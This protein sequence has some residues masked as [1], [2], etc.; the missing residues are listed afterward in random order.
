M[1]ERVVIKNF[2]GIKDADI[3]FNDKIN[4]IVGNNGV[5][6]STLIEAIA[7]AL[8]Y[9]I[10]Q[11]EITQYLF[12]ATTWK[13]FDERKTLPE[14]VIELYFNESF[15]AEYS[16]KNNSLSLL[17]PGIRLRIACDNSYLTLF[18]EQKEQYKHI[19]CEFY[20]IDRHWFSGETVKQLLIPFTPW[21]ID[22][23]SNTFNNKA[24]QL[25][26]RLISHKLSDTERVQVK[27]CLRALREHFE[28]DNK[29]NEIN[30]S[31]ND[32][33]KDV[34]PDFKLTVDL[35]T[36]TAWNTIL[37]PVLKDIPFSQIGLGDQCIVN[38]LLSLDS[39]NKIERK[40][41]LLI[42]EEPESHLSHTKMYEL[43][44]CL[45]DFKGQIFIT[46]HSSY[47]ANK[48][49]LSNL[50]VL[51]NENGKIC[52]QKIFDLDD[53]NFFARVPNYPTLR[54][55]L[56]KKAIL[57]EGPTD[58]MVLL[59]HFMKEY[60]CHPFAMNIELI[61]VGGVVFKH[62]AQLGA[63]LN[64]KIAIITDNDS[65]PL[66]ELKKKR[67]INQE[68]NVR[69]F[70]EENTLIHTLEPAFV[71]ANLSNIDKLSLLVR[72]KV[73]SEETEEKLSDY[74]VKHKTEW[75]QKLLEAKSYDYDVPQYI[76]D[77]VNWL[78]N[79]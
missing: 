15:S 34:S 47:V 7:I 71:R 76:K 27:G 54:I 17:A 35:T 6:K 36:K 74:M 5:G 49:S 21:I 58:E 11:L 25:A 69:L 48:L 38:T 39:S 19:P 23:S 61:S 29:V 30:T 79:G 40:E 68:L 66:E 70:S 56:C 24:N 32:K 53:Y 26:T 64:K 78:V 37:C 12:H 31:L 42:V 59:Y 9:G 43:L 67:A 13:D 28:S 55:A 44:N 63:T 50:L 18:Q 4:I 57:V 75:A 46:T 33:I 77:A 16:G 45:D 52:N 3:S 72:G 20:I 73:E 10:N 41:K 62:F 14:I 51:G 2:K 65:S 22:S 8:G 1:I 60:Q